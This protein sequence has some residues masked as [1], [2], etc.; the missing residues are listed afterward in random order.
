M[1][2]MSRFHIAS[3]LLLLAIFLSV[4]GIFAQIP[5]S[6][7]K[8]IEKQYNV[9]SGYVKVQQFATNDNDTIINNLQEAFFISTPKDLKYIS[10]QNSSFK[11]STSCKSN[12]ARVIIET[13]KDFDITRYGYDD[14]IFDAKNDVRLLNDFSFPSAYDLSFLLC[15]NCEYQRITPKINKK[16]S[17]MKK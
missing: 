10:N 5:K 8:F 11:L 7:F 2:K 17:D 6:L 16:I 12:H 4:Y 9:K 14:K 13:W 1:N 3:S 15:E